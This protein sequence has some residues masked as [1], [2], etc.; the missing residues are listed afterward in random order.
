[1]PRPKTQSECAQINS[2]I[3]EL[4]KEH[5]RVSTKDVVAIFDLHCTTVEK[6]IRIAVLRGDLIRYGR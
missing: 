2:M 6:Y 4:V 5:G 1:M 3:I